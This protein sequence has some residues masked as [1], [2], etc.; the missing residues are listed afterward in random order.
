L[1]GETWTS[2][3]ETMTALRA[4]PR[5]TIRANALNSRVLPDD[6]PSEI[7]FDEPAAIFM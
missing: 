4:F 3:E 2:G 5:L 6:R 1:T 7:R